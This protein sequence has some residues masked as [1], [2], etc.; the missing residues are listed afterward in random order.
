[1]TCWFTN[2]FHYRNREFIMSLPR[3]IFYPVIAVCLLALTGCSTTQPSTAELGIA[4]QPTGALVITQ[5]EWHSQNAEFLANPA[6]LMKLITATLVAKE[7]GADYRFNTHM[8]YKKN[9]VKRGVLRTPL[10]LV[11]Q[12]DPTFTVEHLRQLLK[13]V[14]Q[15]GVK[16]V[17]S[18]AIDVSRY[19]GH[20]WAVGQVWNDHGICFAAPASAAIINRNCVYGNIKAPVV[21]QKTRLHITPGMP[22]H[23]ENQVVTV[24]DAQAAKCEFL[25][26]VK[27]L[28]EYLLTGCVSQQKSRIPLGFSTNA[29]NLFLA[30]LVKQELRS[31]GMAKRVKIHIIDS[32]NKA[33]E[34]PHKFAIFTHASKKVSELIYRMLHRSDNLIADS[35]FKESGFQYS[36]RKNFDQVYGSYSSGEQAAMDLLN[37]L[38]ID[39][40]NLV[41]RD[42]SGLSRENLVF[43]DTFYQLLLSWQTNAKYRWLIDALPIAGETGTLRDRESVQDTVLKG[44]VFA[45]TGTMHGVRNLA[46]FVDAEQGLQP[47]VVMVNKFSRVK[48][49]DGQLSPQE[50][51]LYNFERRFLQQPLMD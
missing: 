12:G 32:P 46:G 10:R 21:G 34:Q 1:M 22:L 50:E 48:S 25:L 18:L 9:A 36:M 37:T 15:S 24:A 16:K 51:R 35:L 41:L 2:M 3:R 31:L 42:G 14:K 40:T 11:M 19:S 29:P 4:E 39:T 6:S 20:Q 17:T 27:N 13:Q 38:K 5:S 26:E 49:E 28:N 44:K 7:L 33:L 23:I 47:F 43:A 8:L 45:K 30:E